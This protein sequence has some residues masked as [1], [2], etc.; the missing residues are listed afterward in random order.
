MELE[1][2]INTTLT[3]MNELERKMAVLTRYLYFSTV[4]E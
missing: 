1:R 3:M 4:V 2:T